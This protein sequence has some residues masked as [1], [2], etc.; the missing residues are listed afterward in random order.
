[1]TVTLHQLGSEIVQAAAG[2]RRVPVDL[3]QVASD[4]G[5][6]A[7]RRS[8][9]ADSFTD[10]GYSGPVIYLGE[11]AN[12]P[13][14]RFIFAHEL[15]H[16]M[17]RMPESA[18]ILSRRGRMDLLDDEEQLANRIAEAILI[19]DPYVKQMSWSQL[20]PAIV[21]RAARHAEV[22]TMVMVTRLASAGLDI[23]ILHWQR[24]ASSWQVVDRPGTPS[25]LH[26]HIELSAE[27]MGA[28]ESVGE[29]ESDV[30]LHGVVNDRHVTLAGKGY[31]RG[32]NFW[33]YIRPTCDIWFG[34]CA[35]ES[36]GRAGHRVLA[37][38]PSGDNGAGRLASECVMPAGSMKHNSPGPDVDDASRASR[39]TGHRG[40]E[41]T[42]RP[43]RGPRPVPSAVSVRG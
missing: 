1:M 36:S 27:S 14:N 28:I 22:S 15:A 23:A 17:L 29:A 39:D 35:G 43:G 30:L 3:A 12:G 19:P 9:F 26:S 18:Q 7:V 4:I 37:R 10:F 24:S 16:V 21:S 40:I 34:G 31:R 11:M 6:S 8:P 42:G 5:V 13:R 38:S 41:R 32:G 33:H 2:Q 25:Y 20:T